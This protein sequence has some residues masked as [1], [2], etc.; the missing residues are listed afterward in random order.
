[1]VF[2]R[3]E[4]SHQYFRWFNAEEVCGLKDALSQLWVVCYERLSSYM[5]GRSR[6]CSCWCWSS[7]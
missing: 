2:P 5:L 1:M 3:F 4:I 6:S 7:S